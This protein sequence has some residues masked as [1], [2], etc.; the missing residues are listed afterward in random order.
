MPDDGLSNGLSPIWCFIF[1]NASILLLNHYLLAIL[2]IDA[3]LGRLDIELASVEVI[4]TFVV[5]DIG[6]DN[7]SR[8]PR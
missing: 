4:K 3:M 1:V 6:Y 7:H 8:S 5:D 2:D